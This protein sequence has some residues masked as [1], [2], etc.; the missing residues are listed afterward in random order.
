[1][2]WDVARAVKA[3]RPD[4][5]VLL[6]TGWADVAYPADVPRVE[7]II[8]KPFDLKQLAAVVSQ[9]LAASVQGRA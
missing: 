9:A 2:G 6:L 4:I 3:T 8:K 7:G 5:P 1:M